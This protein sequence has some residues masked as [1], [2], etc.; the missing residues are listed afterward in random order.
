MNRLQWTAQ[1]SDAAQADGWDVFDL[2]SR[3]FLQIQKCDEAQTELVN[4][5][6]AVCHVYDQAARGSELHRK[7]IMVTLSM[8][9][10]NSDPKQRAY[11]EADGCVCPNCESVNVSAR[12]GDVDGAMFW[13]NVVCNDC[14]AQWVD[15]YFLGGFGELEVKS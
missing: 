2:D 13:Q 7:A 3:G 10:G 9:D 14:E 12:E 5:M 1:D 11:V 15:H 8:K 6:D 4:D